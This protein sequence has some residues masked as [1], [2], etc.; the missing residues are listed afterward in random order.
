MILNEEL[1]FKILESANLFPQDKGAYWLVVCP[2]C[3]AKE[4]FC[5]KK[6]DI[7]ICSR[8]NMCGAVNNLKDIIKKSNLSIRDFLPEEEKEI[9]EEKVSVDLVLPEGLKYFA[10][11]ETSIVKTIARNYLLSR[12]FKDDLINELGYVYNSNNVLTNNR[13]FIPFLENGEIV[14]YVLR[15]FN[16]TAKERYLNAPGLLSSNFVYNLDKIKENETLFIFEGLFDALSL[17]GQI[18]TATL[19]DTISTNQVKK[20]WDRAPGLIVLVPDNDKA[21]N[22]TIER[23]YKLLNHYKPPSLKTEIRIYLLEGFKDLNESSKTYIDIEETISMREF[24][25]KQ[26]LFKLLS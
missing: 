18:G 12:G 10:T 21:G 20:I 7:I 5:Y 22:K 1:K 9:F 15:D 23:N 8:K 2:D 16:G 6:N 13:I 14:F 19:T 4:A 3:G 24:L 17:K 26:K 25:I 11:E